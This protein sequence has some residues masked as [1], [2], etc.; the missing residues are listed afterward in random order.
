MTENKKRRD[1]DLEQSS[2]STVVKS[3]AMVDEQ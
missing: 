1:E 2:S 3:I